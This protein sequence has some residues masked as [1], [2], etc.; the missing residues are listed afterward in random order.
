MS[1]MDK[2]TVNVTAR[3]IR[4]RNLKL[5]FWSVVALICVTIL[6]IFYAF[7][8]FANQLGNF[9]VKIQDKNH[10][11][12]ALC[13]TI[14]FANP[15]TYLA[16]DKIEAMDN[17]AEESIPDDVDQIDGQHNG[18]NYIAITFYLKN[19]SDDLV[20]YQADLKILQVTKE[21]DE[22]IRVKVYK[23]GEDTLYAKAQKGTLTPEPNTTA[24]HSIDKVLSETNTN[25]EPGEVD[26]YTVVVWLEGNDPE[27]IDN[28]IG[29]RVRLAMHFKVI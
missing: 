17:I 25:F 7:V 6:L 29:G 9:T 15:T 13:E 26:K 3:K 12:I 16:A 5:R 28:I 20:S 4:R 18:E 23:N 8:H 10:G 22:A 2:F 27:C 11:G 1:V 14:D 21:A 19:V 24:F